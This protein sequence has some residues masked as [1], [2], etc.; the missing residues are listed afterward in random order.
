[1]TDESIELDNPD[2]A[3]EE[4]PKKKSDIAGTIMVI[5]SILAFGCLTAV[6]VLQ[7]LEYSYYRGGASKEGDP[8]AAQVLIPPQQ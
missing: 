1:M 7:W 4:A 5:F 6:L 3:P 8:Y 2:A